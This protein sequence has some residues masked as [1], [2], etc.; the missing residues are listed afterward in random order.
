MA[1][2]RTVGDADH[3]LQ[4]ALRPVDANIYLGLAGEELDQL[5]HKHVV[6]RSD[7]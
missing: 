7:G 3:Q 4:A 1:G 6:A 5:F 2:D